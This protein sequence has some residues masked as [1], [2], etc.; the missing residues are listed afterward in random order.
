MPHDLPG[1]ELVVGL[2]EGLGLGGREGQLDQ[3]VR[4]GGMPPLQQ[5]EGEVEEREGTDG[6]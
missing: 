4:E 6:G 3:P 1:E 2:P 5:E